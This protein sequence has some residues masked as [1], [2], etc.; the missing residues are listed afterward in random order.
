MS[1]C[2]I[3]VIND[4]FMAV[5]KK[6]G[7]TSQNDERQKS[8]D[9]RKTLHLTGVEACNYLVIREYEA[10]SAWQTGLH[11]VWETD[12]KARKIIGPFEQ[13]IASENQLTAG[14][15]MF[16]FEEEIRG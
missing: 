15:S 7:G 6:K 8:R 4:C 13:D 11:F 5:V 16:Y 1:Y 3:S 14:V 10:Q 2:D 9:K 12:E